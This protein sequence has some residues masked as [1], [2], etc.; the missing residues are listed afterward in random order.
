MWQRH[1]CVTSCCRLTIFLLQWIGFLE[2]HPCH[3][4]VLNIL[5][6][7]TIFALH[8]RF[9][10]SFGHKNYRFENFETHWSRVAKVSLLKSRFHTLVTKSPTPNKIN[11][12][13]RRPEQNKS[14]LILYKNSRGH[15]TSKS[16]VSFKM[17]FLL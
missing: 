11:S 6:L 1:Y 8:A 17:I 16:E 2:R 4:R 12:T 15:P 5:V 10:M 14:K 3:V 13:G 7:S 9:I